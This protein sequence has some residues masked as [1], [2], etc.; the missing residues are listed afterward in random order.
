MSL[1]RYALDGR[2]LQWN[3]SKTAV[4]FD[5]TESEYFSDLNAVSSS[6]LR[7]VDR[8]PAHART[9]ALGHGEDT[10]SQRLG[11]AVHCAVLEPER[12]AGA[13]VR[14]GGHRRGYRWEAFAERH[15]DMEILNEKEWE[16]VEGCSESV[17]AALLTTAGGSCSVSDL[18]AGGQTE[19]VVYWLDHDTGL[20]CRARMDIM[21]RRGVADLKTT[22]DA[23]P[24]AFAAQCGRQGY[25]LQ[26]A[27]YL[28]GERQLTDSQ[29]E[30][31][32]LLIAAELR[33]PHCCLVYPIDQESFLEAG[34]QA[35]REALNRYLACVKS[36][37]WAG[38]PAVSAPLRLPL[39]QRFPGQGLRI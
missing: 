36:G 23:R 8:S 34:I 7:E 26:A 15:S 4:A 20:T 13:Y 1:P 19:R 27:H 14:W 35:R 39:S 32:Y 3:S 31:P 38:Y 21:V 16:I 33:A 22:D 2:E 12:F 10:P 17:R 5:S 24:D 18:I 25:H 9:A 6:M 11:R 30:A 37:T 28:A 29:S